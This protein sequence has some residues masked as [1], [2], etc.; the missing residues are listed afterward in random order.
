VIALNR[1]RIGSGSLCLMLL[2]NVWRL[3]A[4]LKRFGERRGPPW[5]GEW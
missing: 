1:F 2:V 5:E 3:Q 4:S